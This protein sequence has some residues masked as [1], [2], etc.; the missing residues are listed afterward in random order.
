MLSSVCAN[1]LCY[2]AVDRV[3]VDDNDVDVGHRIADA[4][5]GSESDHEP[6]SGCMGDHVGWAVPLRY[7]IADD[8]RY[9]GKSIK[10]EL[11]RPTIKLTIFP[12]LHAFVH[13]QNDSDSQDVNVHQVNGRMLRINFK[14]QKRKLRTIPKMRVAP[15]LIGTTSERI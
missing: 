7:N 6:F 5:L 8:T 11:R 14:T 2:V 15:I 1:C 10:I 12:R 4:E 3:G 9:I 13:G